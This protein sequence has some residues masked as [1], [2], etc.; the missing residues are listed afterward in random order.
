MNI[1]CLLGSPRPRGNSTAIAKH[2]CTIAEEKGNA[3]SREDILQLS[4]TTAE[5]LLETDTPITE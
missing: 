5:G 4:R 2:F 1:V 3:D